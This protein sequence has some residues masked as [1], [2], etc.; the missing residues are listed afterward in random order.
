MA[1][2]GN[3]FCNCMNSVLDRLNGT[4]KDQQQQPSTVFGW[5]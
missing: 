5:V 1:M 3:M 4:K 2:F